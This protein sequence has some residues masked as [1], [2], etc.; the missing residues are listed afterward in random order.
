LD[1]LQPEMLVS[2]K[3]NEAKNP[4]NNLFIIISLILFFFLDIRKE[5]KLK[6]DCLIAGQ[7]VELMLEYLPNMFTVF[8]SIPSNMKAKKR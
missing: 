2:V 7:E 5:V 4:L 3:Y 8:H 1:G 6:E